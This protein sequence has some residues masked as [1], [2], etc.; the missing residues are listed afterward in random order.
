MFPILKKEFNLFFG[1]SLGYFVIGGFLILNSLLLWFF[2]SNYNI[3]DAGFADLTHFFTIVPWLFI[4]LIP[5]LTMRS[6]SEEISTG[7][8]EILKTKPLS[9]KQVLLGKYAAVMCII[10]VA[11][12]PTFVYLYSIY[13]LANPTGNIDFGLI[14]GSYLG[15]LFMAS[16]FT[17]I[18]LWTSTFSNNP[19]VVLLASIIISF[20]IYYGLYAITS[21]NESSYSIQSLGMFLH[22]ESIGRGVIDSRDLIYFIS[23]SLFFLTLT[24]TRMERIKSWKL[25]GY[26][27][28]FIIVLNFSSNKIY[29]RLDLTS[30]KKYTLSNIS[31][32]IIQAINEPLVIRVYLEGEFPSEFKRLQIETQQLLTELKAKN[33]NIKVLFIDPQNDLEKLIEKGLAPSRL[34]VEENGVVSESVI[35]PWATIHFQNRM[36]Q[37]SLL[38][39]GSLAET[40]EQQLENSIQNL[41]Y[42]LVDGI[43]RV[44]TQKEKSIAVLAGNGELEDIYLYG[45]LKSLGSY[46][47]LAKFTLDSVAKNPVKTFEQLSKYDLAIIAKPTEAFSEEEKYL[48]DQYQLQG[49]KSLWLVD[50]VHAEL[51]SLLQSGKTLAY[52]RDLNLDDFFFRYGARI[53]HNIIKDLYA[54]KISLA[55]GNTGNRANFENFLW[56]YHP[57]ITPLGKH[58]IVKNL[59]GIQLKFPSNIDTLQNTI[60]KTVLLES[61]V[62]SQICE[63]P[64]FI[65]LNSVSEQPDPQRYNQRNLIAGVLLEGE[66][67]SAYKDRQKPLNLPYA[68]EVGVPSKLI[69]ISDGDIASNQI[70]QGQPLDLGV[71][72]WTQEYYHNKEFLMNAVDYLLDDTGLLELRNKKI[73]LRTLNKSLITQNRTYWQLFNLIVPLM[74]LGVFGAAFLFYR[75]K[76][77]A[78]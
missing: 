60:K 3:L 57:L 1:A 23:V 62:L 41:E 70:H 32:E 14:I 46:Y 48:L 66:F 52:P 67:T 44:S 13:Q 15:L 7:T 22:F 49:G 72:K 68:T 39:D 50:H 31:E 24:N 25:F 34:T 78:N 64:N 35:L 10:S 27:S 69:L 29:K 9:N 73:V 45:Y 30:D 26:V 71:D 19:L 8:I 36:E 37:V 40:Q 33:N 61:S 54:S 47:H 16:A 63:T 4:L 5:A 11:L 20:G 74:I 53:N 12:V 38:K 56:F 65:E 77:Y 21:N 51:D 6:F 42:A 58:P 2:K 55:T 59:G 76:K 17:A 18:G 43:K 28:L 75:K